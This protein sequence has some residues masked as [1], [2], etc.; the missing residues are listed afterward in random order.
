[1]PPQKIEPPSF[2]SYELEH[3]TAI[4]IVGPSS[5]GKMTLCNALA[6][7]LGLPAE[8]YVTEV[9]RTVMREQGFSRADVDKLD[10]QQAIV[11]AHIA[12]DKEARLAALRHS[13]RNN[14]SF[15]VT[16]NNGGPSPEQGSGGPVYPEQPGRRAVV[17]CDRSA[18]DAAVYARL[19]SPAAGRAIVGSASFRVA[20]EAYRAQRAL[21]V[22]LSPVAEWLVDDGV[23]SLEDGARCLEMFR[24]VLRELGIRHMEMDVCCRFLEERVAFVRRIGWV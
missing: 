17:L 10:M 8:A 21:I 6:K 15:S 23:R 7:Q 19:G 20:L 11:D 14:A 24:V 12:R 16:N 5:T 1:M 18:L 2:T 9:A 4:Y 13:T 3:I 22:L